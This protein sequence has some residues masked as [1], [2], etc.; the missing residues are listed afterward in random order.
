MAKRDRRVESVEHSRDA[1]R[2][3]FTV[4]EKQPARLPLPLILAALGVAALVLGAYL[5]LSPGNASAPG[6]A[7]SAGGPSVRRANA[8]FSVVDPIGGQISVPL[9]SLADGKARYYTL[10]ASAKEIDFYVL[11]ASDGSIRAAID[12]CDVCFAARKGY[13]QE[14]DEMVCNNC[15]QRFPS[16]K[17]G[18]VKGSCN[19]VPLGSKV[20]GDSVTIDADELSREG[21]RY[22]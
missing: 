16:V 8:T 13:R 17:I 21:A 12:S 3:Q 15:G 5:V 9:S 4:Q 11:K 1:K 19:P 14:G 18:E 2:R 10:R 22:F 7:S 20:E 6:G